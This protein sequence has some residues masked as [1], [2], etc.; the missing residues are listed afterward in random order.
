MIYQE[1]V[2]KFLI[3]KQETEGGYTGNDITKLAELLQVTS[4]GLRKRLSFWIKTDK[5]F[6]QFIY[7]GKEKPSI[8]L[9]SEPISHGLKSMTAASEW[10][11][12]ILSLIKFIV[13]VLPSPH[14][15][16]SA[17]IRLGDLSLNIK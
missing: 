3:E 5:Q 14:F 7:L 12:F 9:S 15:P 11:S 6:S 16:S 13:E 10:F 4:R 2:L 17:N 1:Q 8:T